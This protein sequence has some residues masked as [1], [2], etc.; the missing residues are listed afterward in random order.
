V[1]VYRVS[2]SHAL[3][4][5]VLEAAG[6]LKYFTLFEQLRRLEILDAELFVER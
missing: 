1:D 2:I 6:L 4:R 3:A 5:A